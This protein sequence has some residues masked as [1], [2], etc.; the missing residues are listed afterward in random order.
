MTEARRWVA[1]E[2]GG[3]EV[4]EEIVFEL[5]DRAQAK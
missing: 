3:P 4:L 1:K 2:F 5:A